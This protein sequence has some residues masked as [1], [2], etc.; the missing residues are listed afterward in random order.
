MF[1]YL[2]QDASAYVRDRAGIL[3]VRVYAGGEGQDGTG[4]DDK[5]AKDGKSA[6][7]IPPHAPDMADQGAR[8]EARPDR[9]ELQVP[10][11]RL[12]LAFCSSAFACPR[13]STRNPKLYALHGNL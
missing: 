2:C 3:C 7:A 13:T 9:L 4:G 1:V 5:S 12:A 10:P 6:P 11:R 8:Q